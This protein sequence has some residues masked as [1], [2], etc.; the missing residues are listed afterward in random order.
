MTAA[1]IWFWWTLT[2]CSTPSNEGLAEACPSGDLDMAS[3]A[4]RVAR[5][6]RRSCR[7]DLEQLATYSCTL[8]WGASWSSWPLDLPLGGRPYCSN[9]STCYA[10]GNLYRSGD[11]P[12]SLADDRSSRQGHNPV[13]SQ[14]HLQPRLTLLR[15]P[16]VAYRHSKAHGGGGIYSAACHGSP[17][18]VTPSAKDRDNQQAIR[19]QSH[20]GPIDKCTLCYLEK[21]EGDFW[22]F[23]SEK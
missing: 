10:Q 15:H 4:A 14:S 17:H 13:L 5:D 11:R 21:P 7:G 12:G 22:H 1:R 20:E 9:W 16:H 6:V 23:A 3:P 18:A 8:R 19:L 2:I